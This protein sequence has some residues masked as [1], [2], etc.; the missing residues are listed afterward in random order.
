[1]GTCFNCVNPLKKRQFKYCSNKCQVEH[2]YKSCIQEWKLNSQKGRL[3]VSTKNI[4]RHIKR[5][6]IQLTGERCSVCGWGERH[7]ITKRVPLEVD[8]IDANADNNNES[9]LRIL[10][11]NC[12]SLTVHFRNLNRT[13]GRRWRTQYAQKRRV[14]PSS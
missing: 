6:L 3:R 1:M 4:S 12:H 10:C 9:N 5:Y 2:Q 8:H 13:R 7:P 11:P 14:T